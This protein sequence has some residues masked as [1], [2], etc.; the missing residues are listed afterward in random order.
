[1]V[2]QSVGQADLDEP[3]S[4]D[5]ESAGLLIDFAQQIYRKVDVHA[6]DRTTRPNRLGEVHV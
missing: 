3:L 4:R 5:A 1:M 6:L 2:G